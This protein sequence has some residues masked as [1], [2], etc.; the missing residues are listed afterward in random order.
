MMKKCWSFVLILSFTCYFYVT[1]SYAQ[2]SF[3][4]DTRAGF[5]YHYA[6][7][8]PEYPFLN[9]LANSH[10]DIYELNVSKKVSG[11]QLWHHVYRYPYIGFSCFYSEL[12]NDIVFGKAF[13]LNP[14]IGFNLIKH[15]RFSL[16]YRFGIGLTYVTKHFD[17]ETNYQD[18]PVGS[19]I[20]I[21]LNSELN[22][23]LTIA[24]RYYL[25]AGFGFNHLSNANL[26]EPNIGLNYLTFLIGSEI[27]FADKE[28]ENRVE[29][30]PFVKKTEYSVDIGGCIKK[31]R[32]FA[33]ETYFAGSVSFQVRRYLGYPIAVG[34]GADIFYDSSIPDEM[35]LKGIPI[36]KPIYKYK[37][38]LHIAEELIVGKISLVIEEGLYIGL[39]DKLENYKMY[40]RGIVRYKF[41]NHWYADMAMKSNLF[42]LDVMELGVGYY[43]N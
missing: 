37:T 15:P 19:H 31:T 9:Y 6:Y 23:S 39:T 17:P 38:G 22:G 26:A 10:A 24:G 35:N 28:A 33:P 3:W 12:G 7:L 11:K 36:I 27:L 30:P 2:N 1:H 25:Y 16:K 5:N 41:S 18:I 34:A 40:N 21:W 29:V 32:R 4:E 14:H 13:A 20:N 43:W 42:I 8:L